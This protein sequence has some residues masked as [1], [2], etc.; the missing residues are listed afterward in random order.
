MGVSNNTDDNLTLKKLENTNKIVVIVGASGS[1]KST[2]AEKLSKVLDIKKLITTTT[3]PMRKYESHEEDYYFISENKFKE[4]SNSK[5]FL[6][7]NIYSGYEYGLTRDE[8]NKNKNN[9][10][11]VITD[12]SGARVLADEHPD[13]VMIFWMKSSPSLLIKRLFHRGDNVRT[14]ICRLI[15]AF[16]KREFTSPMKMFTDVS[17]TELS[18]SKPTIDNFGIIYYRLLIEEFNY[19]S[20]YFKK[21]KLEQQNRKEEF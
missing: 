21:L 17:F 7:Q 13:R 8:I 18:S 4:M 12:V 11:Y 16:T 1:G 9:I 10:C 15:N 5:L 2:L 6:E 3:R 19:N 20:V 14:I